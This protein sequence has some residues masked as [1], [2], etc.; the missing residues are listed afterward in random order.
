MGEG[1]VHVA[2][3]TH[4]PDEVLCQAF[5]KALPIGSLVVPFWDYLVGF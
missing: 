3:V 4:V 5:P 1:I 2:N